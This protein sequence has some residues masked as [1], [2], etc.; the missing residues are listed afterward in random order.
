MQLLLVP[1]GILGR[2]AV[3]R[4]DLLVPRRARVRVE[5]SE[6]CRESG[7]LFIIERL[8]AEEDDLV[9]QDGGADRVALRR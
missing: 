5:R 2:D 6:L 3:D 4:R 7:V 9:F 8:V 1:G